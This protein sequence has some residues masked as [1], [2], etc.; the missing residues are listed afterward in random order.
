MIVRTGVWKQWSIPLSRFDGV[1]LTRVKKLY[2]GVGDH[3]N[4]TP[5]DGVGRI[6]ID[7]IRLT[8]P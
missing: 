8:R 4:P 3:E 1:N 6:Y 5:T 2:I 7:D